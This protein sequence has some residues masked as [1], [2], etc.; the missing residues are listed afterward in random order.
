MSDQ[1]LAGT[2]R[3]TPTAR[4]PE[5][6]GESSTQPEINLTQQST[7]PKSP[8][9]EAPWIPEPKP[10]LV[11]P[12]PIIFQETPAPQPNTEA[13]PELTKAQKDEI[14]ARELMALGDRLRER[15]QL[16][17]AMAN[18]GVPSEHMDGVQVQTWIYNAN[19]SFRTLSPRYENFLPC[20]EDFYLYT[21]PADMPVTDETMQLHLVNCANRINTT[22]INDKP[23]RPEFEIDGITP[24]RREPEPARVRVTTNEAI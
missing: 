11:D 14:A 7:Q 4:R 5:A 24:V 17:T 1:K 2:L 15:A 13:V 3:R 18:S 10:D 22:K 6:G 16:R 9:D 8:I 12:T 21:P 19:E 23:F 20:G